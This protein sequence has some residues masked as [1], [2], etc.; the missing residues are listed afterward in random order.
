[1]EFLWTG[2]GEIPDRY[3]DYLL[4]KTFGALP[5]L[6]N[7]QDAESI[8]EFLVFMEVEAQVQKRRP[9]QKR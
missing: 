3:T 5:T 7:D 2:V 4:C 1:M 6:L 8:N 9:G